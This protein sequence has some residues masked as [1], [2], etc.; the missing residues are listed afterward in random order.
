MRAWAR[1]K[2][3][4]MSCA[5]VA[6]KSAAIARRFFESAA[7]Q[8][9]RNLFAF[10]STGNEPDTLPILR[11]ALCAGKSVLVPVCVEQGHMVAQQIFSLEELI[12][13]RHG[14]LAPQRGQAVPPEEIE[15]VAVPGLAFDESL[16]RLG[17]GGGYYDRFLA[18]TRAVFIALAYEWQM[19]E[20]VPMH[21]LDQ[22]MDL[23]VTER[24][25]IGQVP[26]SK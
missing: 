17:M 20:T 14:I 22:K 4:R 7:Y 8:Q 16:G 5:E 6:E 13:G 18:S 3:A 11:A 15:L 19:V 23:I 26:V 25:T 1:E 2:R 21:R 24:R 12:P 10:V 9:A